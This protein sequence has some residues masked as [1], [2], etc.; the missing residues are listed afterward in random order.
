MRRMLAKEGFQMYLLNEFRTSSLCPSCQNGELETFK[1]VQNPRPYQREK[2]LIVDR[3]GLL[4][5]IEDTA[6]FPLRRLWNR[7]MAA[8]LNFGYILFSLRANGERPERFCRSKKPL[9]T[10]PKRKNIPSSSASTSRPTKRPNN[11]L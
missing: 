4:S 3:H 9:S 8:T 5:T 7:D 1:K 6:K 11:P 2:R 10:G